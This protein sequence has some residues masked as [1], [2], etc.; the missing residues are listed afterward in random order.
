MIISMTGYGEAENKYKNMNILISISS[1]NSRFLDCNLKMI[2]SF[3][4]FE[5]EIVK[6]IKKRCN[7]GRITVIIDIEYER[8]RNNKLEIKEEKLLQYQEI[9]KVIKEKTNI[10]NDIRLDTFLNL[11]DLV[12]EESIIKNDEFKKIFFKTLIFALEDLNNMRKIEGRNIGADLTKRLKNISNYILE[13]NKS[14]EEDKEGSYN[15]FLKKLKMISNEIKFDKNR[16]LQELVI[17][18][19]KKD[20]T[21]EIVRIQSHLDLFSDFVNNNEEAGKKM[22]FLH[23]EMLREI[24]TIG[25]KTGNIIISHIV[26]E[27]KEELEKIKEQVQNI[28]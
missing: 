8:S 9:I 13:I 26:V 2:K 20:I 15:Q 3:Y 12:Y 1:L 25:S 11:P 16:I 5:S 7:R 24:N 22:N 6:E 28:L 17:L 4:L 10:K 14:L 27:I 18:A 19:E 23:Q 21:E